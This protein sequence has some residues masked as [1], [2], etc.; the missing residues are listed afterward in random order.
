MNLKGAVD[1]V[2]VKVAFEKPTPPKNCTGIRYAKITI[3]LAGGCRIPIG[4]TPL[5]ISGFEG[6]IYD[7]DYMS[8]GARACYIP[9]LPPGLKV[10]AAMF[11]ELEDPELVNEKVGFWVHLRKL[12]FG[13]SG[14]VEALQGIA[15][16]DACLALYNN[17]HAFHGHFNIMIHMGLMSRG[18]FVID[19]WKDETGGNFTADASAAIGLSRG[20]L[21]KCKLI[22]I[23]RK[24]RWFL[25]LLTKAGKFSNEKNGMATGLRFFG[26]SWGLGVIGGKFSVGNMGKFKLKQAP[27]MMDPPATVPPSALLKMALEEPIIPDMP[28]EPDSKHPIRYVNPGFKLEG[29]EVIS[30]VAAT[31]SSNF[32]WPENVLRIVDADSREMDLDEVDY[33]PFEG[34]GDDTAKEYFVNDENTVARLWVNNKNYD[35][36]LVAMPDVIDPETNQPHGGFEY[37][38]FAGLKPARIESISASADDT[39]NTH[40]VTFNC[41]ISNFRGR[42]RNLIRTD[43]MGIDDTLLRQKMKL[44]LYCSSISPRPADTAISENY[45]YNYME[46]PVSQFV[47]Y[48]SSQLSLLDNPDVVYDSIN[49]TLTVTNLKWNTD[50]TAPGKYALRAG[51]EV[52]DF[53]TEDGDGK[54]IILPLEKEDEAPV[55][56]EDPVVITY[57]DKKPVIIN[58]VSNM[59]ITK[60]AG[61]TATGSEA[62][63]NWAET[64]ETRSIF[65]RWHMDNNPSVHGYQ[66]SWYPSN[67][68]DSLKKKLKRSTYIGK[69]DNYT[70]TI[71]HLTANDS[72]YTDACDS[73]EGK[74]VLICDTV[75][76]SIVYS[77]QTDSASADSP[78]VIIEKADTTKD[79]V[80]FRHVTEYNTTI[81]PESTI[82]TRPYRLCPSMIDTSYYKATAFDVIITPVANIPDV[83]SD[84]D[85][86]G[87]S[88]SAIKA[89]IH[90][91]S[92]DTITNVLLGVNKGLPRNR[93]KLSLKPAL[94]PVIVPLN[95]GTV[96]NG[97]L[98]V[99]EKDTADSASRYGELWAKVV[100]DS[101]SLSAMPKAGAFNNYFTV[102]RE[103][104]IK[105]RVSI[106]PVEK[107]V[108]CREMFGST[109]NKVKV[110]SGNGKYT[111]TTAFQACT[112]GCSPDTI[113]TAYKQLKLADPCHGEPDNLVVQRT[114]FDTYQMYLY[115]VNNGKRRNPVYDTSGGFSVYDS[116]LFSVVPPRPVL[117]GVSPYYV[118]KGRQDT[119]SLAVSDLWLDSTALS[120][121]GIKVR[122]YD[123]Y[124]TEYDTIVDITNDPAIFKPMVTGELKRDWKLETNA[125]W[126]VR[127]STKFIDID[128]TGET[129]LFISVVNRD[130][131]VHNEDVSCTSNEFRVSYVYN[132]DAIECPDN[133]Y[134]PDAPNASFLMDWI[135]NYPSDS[136]SPNDSMFIRFTE[137]HDLD[138]DHYSVKLIKQDGT[139]FDTANITSFK[140]DY[141]GI[142]IKLPETLRISAAKIY[143]VSTRL[144][145]TSVVPKCKNAIWSSKFSTVPAREYRIV[146][147]GNGF[148]I[149]A[150]KGKEYRNLDL[151]RYAIGKVPTPAQVTIGYD[152]KSDPPQKV[153]MSQS[154][155]VTA[156]IKRRSG[157]ETT[158]EEW[159]DI[160]NVPQLYDNNG[161]PVAD[162]FEAEP[163]DSFFIRS[164]SQAFYDDNQTKPYHC[165][166]FSDADS[167]L[168][169]VVT[170][171]A[172]SR[173]PLTIYR[174]AQTQPGSGTLK[175]QLEGYKTYNFTLKNYNKNEL[176][177][178]IIPSQRLLNAASD[179]VKDYPLLLRLDSTSAPGIDTLL[180]TKKFHFRDALMRPLSFDIEHLDTMTHK[181][182]IWVKMPVIDPGTGNNIVHFVSGL[183]S[184]NPE[185]VWSSYRAVWHSDGDSILR[186]ATGNGFDMPLYSTA[187]MQGIIDS[188]MRMLGQLD[189]SFTGKNLIEE[190][191]PGFTISS[192]V[193]LYEFPAAAKP[194]IKLVNRKSLVEGSIMVTAD[195]GLAFIMGSD[196]L[197]TIRGALEDSIW[198]NIAVTYDWYN[199][200]GAAVIYINGLPVATKELMN[201]D[202]R[203]N[204]VQ[205]ILV[206]SSSLNIAIDELRV[207][208]EAFKRNRVSL[209]YF[210]QR[211]RNDFLKAPSG[212]TSVTSISKSEYRMVPGASIGDKIC[213]SR[214]WRLETILPDLAGK[215]WLLMPWEERL[216]NEDTLVTVH[217]NG[218]AMIYLLFDSR[219]TSKPSFLRSWTE[220]GRAVGVNGPLNEQVTMNLYTM[221]IDSASDVIFGGPRSGGARGGEL[222]WAVLMDFSQ[223][224][225]GFRVSVKDYPFVRTDRAVN[226]ELLFSDREHEID[227]IPEAL[228]NGIMIQTPNAFRFSDSSSFVSF[229]VNR[230]ATA[231]I[232]MDTA[233]RSWPSFIN[234]DKEWKS[235]EMRVKSGNKYFSVLQK[236]IRNSNTPSLLGGPHFGSGDGNR[237]SYSM[238][239]Q[240]IDDKRIII[241]DNRIIVADTGA[242][243]YTDSLWH[244]ISI[245]GELKGKKLIKT[246]Q[247]KYDCTDSA[248]LKF[249]ILRSCQVYIAIDENQSVPPGFITKKDVKDGTVWEPTDFSVEISNHAKFRIYSK[250]LREGDYSF[251]CARYNGGSEDNTQNYFVIVDT[252]ATNSKGGL[253]DSLPW[254][255]IENK[256]TDIP[257]QLEG[258]EIEKDSSYID[259]CRNRTYEFSQPVRIWLGVDPAFKTSGTFLKYDNW[260][261]TDLIIAVSGLPDRILWRKTFDPGT[262]TIPGVHC[263]FYQPGIMNPITIFEYLNAAT[264][265]L[266]GRD[267]KVTGFGDER[268][269]QTGNYII[270]NLDVVYS[271]EFEMSSR[272]WIMNVETRSATAQSGDTIKVLTPFGDGT[273]YKINDTTTIRAENQFYLA[274]LM[275]LMVAVDSVRVDAID[276]RAQGIVRVAFKNNSTVS[277]NKPFVVILFEDRNGDFT[278]NSY[279]KRLG[280]ITVNNIRAGE[281]KLYQIDLDDTISFPNRTLF[282]FIDATDQIAEM[283]DWNNVGSSGTT[284]ENYLR[285]VFVEKIDDSLNVGR[286][287]H[288]DSLTSGLPSTRDSTIFCYIKDFN[289]DS[290]IDEDDTLDIV[291]TYNNRLYAVNALTH[292]SLFPSIFAGPSAV[293]KIRV[294]DFTNDG[295]PEII[296]GNSLYGNDGS[297]IHDF[298]VYSTTPVPP[299]TLLSLDFDRDGERDTIIF[300]VADSC[301]LIRSGRDSTLLFVYPMSNWSGG[302]DPFTKQ[303]LC[304][305]H[306]GTYNCYDVNVSFPRFSVTLSDTVDLTVRVANAGAAGVNG[307]LVEMFADTLIRDSSLVDGIADLP[308]DLILIGEGRTGKLVSNA[309]MDFLLH[310]V[311]PDNTKRIWFRV[312]GENRYLECNERDNG[313]NIEVK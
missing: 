125:Q 220:T 297:L 31:D 72:I 5:F 264:R 152:H 80:Y 101:V 56:K 26:R 167:V 252:S 177:S 58:I 228:Q 150:V 9:S 265:G 54:K 129:G 103:S 121:P 216:S 21:L 117:H 304:D 227:S 94:L 230:P 219:Y 313:L 35:S 1:K 247:V 202:Q 165:Y 273:V 281:S 68:N 308:L 293:A 272:S 306:Q 48:D 183:K 195:S 182:D 128:T 55:F 310:A 52:V 86:V 51:I 13:L 20:A 105:T 164:P 211:Q 114:P 77:V 22:K 91:D 241:T 188:S 193:K 116:L 115:A 88:Y 209:D 181:A 161:L 59:P 235:C 34:Q 212:I 110:D 237:C 163:G 29:G 301:T 89:E 191:D 119:L 108:T 157:Q 215:Q 64:D 262:V 100:N 206:A 130:K 259:Y 136:L 251:S 302:V 266:Y 154:N 66:I 166:R 260:E 7:G 250:P 180:S 57:V 112:Y 63:T 141:G 95:E 127:L 11:V 254:K 149:F 139:V 253:K 174:W 278:Y 218:P 207:A 32:Q 104:V 240:P 120:W 98:T 17:G 208:P 200:K 93:L 8:D 162:N 140:I 27:V 148:R 294:D 42:I 37:L 173:G 99:M 238:I 290:L 160:E 155:W 175:K 299:V 275:P 204:N 194:L 282:S 81:I 268:R 39:A 142:C 47:G 122:W 4:S 205:R 179:S 185:D 274:E 223:D 79:T 243:V 44:K 303:V 296:A 289:G 135:G 33:I 16:A 14:H 312:D 187:V 25:E 111:D 75:I 189:A 76:D 46:I 87:L 151:V 261:K 67:V 295:I 158:I 97:Q 24:D 30:F 291:Y 90:S 217:L 19:I 286:W 23:P 28:L 38:F 124:G 283:D 78:P 132:P 287:G 279:D 284:C 12:N 210:S 82:V 201:N 84:T 102:K 107:N 137:L 307:V 145:D 131:D 249:S 242:L 106:R 49:D 203:I 118:L 45:P 73:A 270:K 309:F 229:S 271:Y 169:D 65:L 53:V 239:L 234:D 168:G 292:D 198:L 298:S 143:E 186:D 146:K 197:R 85:R 126:E 3:K 6:A 123:K 225:T 255:D 138:P 222:P 2:E 61:F 258:L 199:T 276:L 267:L 92:A 190:N 248:Y 40:Q 245:N 236:R 96:V 192:W 269:A 232:L 43:S 226:G 10:E 159:I 109:C 246:Q 285:P 231:S 144:V 69:T 256:I 305:I 300:D 113:D 263:D 36:I 170:M 184:D 214:N 15:D 70:I 147:D 172:D 244:I 18:R 41:K 178:I 280:S 83:V 196:T 171:N 74:A 60:P 221:Q 50:K 288:V 134:D 71:P 153:E 156:V 133:Y 257:E 176:I 277:V 224:N 62:D 311:L 213:T 233:Y